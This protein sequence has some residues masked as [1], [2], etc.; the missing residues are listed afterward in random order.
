[1]TIKKSDGIIT[2]AQCKITCARLGMSYV[3]PSILLPDGSYAEESFRTA[4]RKHYEHYL[5]LKCPQILHTHP[6][7]DYCSAIYRNIHI[8]LDPSRIL[9]SCTV[10]QTSSQVCK[11]SQYGK[12]NQKHYVT[13]SQR[14]SVNTAADKLLSGES[15]TILECTLTGKYPIGMTSTVILPRH[16]MTHVQ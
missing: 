3:G 12:D 2:H 7:Y 9:P 16:E 10:A 15:H 6:Q 11:V 13:N 5:T 4:N 14:L 1:M 8:V